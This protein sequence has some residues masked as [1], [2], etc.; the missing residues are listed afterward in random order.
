MHNCLLTTKR[1][2]IP[3]YIVETPHDLVDDDPEPSE[4]LSDDEKSMPMLQVYLRLWD[5]SPDMAVKIPAKR[6]TIAIKKHVQEKYPSMTLSQ[7]KV[8]L[9]GRLIPDNQD[10]S[11]LVKCS[12]IIQ[13]MASGRTSNALRST[14]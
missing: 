3:M 7:I 13:V 5:E 10:I 1:Y 14:S 9:R 8:M 11:Q 2:E 12:E 6:A 4:K